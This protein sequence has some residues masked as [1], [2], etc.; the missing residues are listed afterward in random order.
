MEKVQE[1]GENGLYIKL[2]NDL[3]N[4]KIV[5]INS[6]LQFYEELEKTNSRWSDETEL[7]KF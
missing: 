4:H 7:N 3:F 6:E 1:N 5:G 2:E